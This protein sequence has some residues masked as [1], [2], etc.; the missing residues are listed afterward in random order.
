VFRIAQ[1]LDG[2]IWFSSESENYLAVPGNGKTR[3]IVSHPFQRMNIIQVNSIYPDPKQNTIWF[4]R[5]DGLYGYDTLYKKDYRQPFTALIRK[6]TLNKG[7]NDQ[8]ILFTD[9][10]DSTTQTGSRPEIRIPYS[11]R[12]IYFQFAAPFYEDEARTRYKCL[13]EGYDSHWTPWSTDTQR[14][15]TNLDAGT[16]RFRVQAKNVYETES[17][18]AE[19]TFRILLPWYRKWWII[20]FYFLFTLFTLY[21]IVRWRSKKLEKEKQRLENT[22]EERTKEINQKN[23]QLEYQTLQLKNQSQKLKEM[24]RVKSRFFANISHEFRTPLTLIL[25]PLE[26]MYPAARNDKE[27]NRIHTMLRNTQRLLLLINQL[28]DL[29]RLDSKKE[30][31]QASE[32]DVIPFLKGIVANF[33]S[34]AEQKKIK[35]EFQT[36]PAPLSFY[37][38]NSK[39]EKVINNL[40][41]N[42]FNY[43]PLHG[44]ITVSVSLQKPDS[45]E[46][47]HQEER[48]RISI[49]D[50]GPGI[51][52]QQIDKIFDRFYQAEH[53]KANGRQGTGIG[54]AIVKEYVQL[55]HGKVDV[56][57]QLHKGTEFVLTFPKDKTHLPPE[58]ITTETAPVP[59]TGSPAPF[60]TQ[61]SWTPPAT[62]DHA[63]TD[64]HLMTDETDE[65]D[66]IDQPPTILV[67]EDNTDVRQYICESLVDDYTVIQA[68][69][70]TEGIEKALKFIPDL[71]VS[72][73]MMPG[74]DGY[75]LCDTLKKDIKTSHIPIILLTA[76]ASQESQLQGLDTGADDYIIKPFNA[77]ILVSR[78]KNLIQL[79]RQLQE[80]FHKQALLQPD[81]IKVSSMDKEFIAEIKEMIEGNLGKED[82]NVEKLSKL[83]F[84]DRTTLFRKI[85]AL[86][87]ETP[88][89]FIR[90]FRLQRAAHLLRHQTGTV[91]Q[92]SSEVGFDNMAYFAKCFRELYKVS[93]SSYMAT[94]NEN[95]TS[96]K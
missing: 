46:D 73:I 77:E 36:S 17:K 47:S 82:F 34:E 70:G 13:L 86:T 56:H 53:T 4:A 43:T 78:I 28:L 39:M 1:D 9:T 30:Q 22:V 45:E 60:P 93:P 57:S 27:K 55:H 90:S 31:L 59:P 72:D 33:E 10:A 80:K 79:R 74:K 41:I 75:Q 5:Y 62:E 14:A 37:F 88:Q 11:R 83:L 66:T 52:P 68:K 54:L 81:E 7:S 69:D 50:S 38:D 51:E 89:L 3:T 61:I 18:E 8:K 24:D 91:S 64:I 23:H 95:K 25:G 65:A 40:L 87:G 32:Q 85:K 42:A 35:L 16:Y 2:R 44:T 67:V 12:N 6:V 63:E 26:Q 76:K 71:I 19:F 96:Q 94:Y 21:G 20:P 84:I 49:K 92:I 58:S 15:F 29:S 48:V